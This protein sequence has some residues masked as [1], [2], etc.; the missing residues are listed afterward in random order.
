MWLERTGIKPPIPGISLRVAYHAPCS[1]Q[2]GQRV[3]GA[4]VALLRQAGFS[5]HEV[6]DG[7]LCCGSAGTYHLL[8]P[9]L[10]DQLRRRKIA[11]IESLQPQAIATGNLGCMLQI[12]SGTALPSLHL[13]QLL[14]WATG[15][16]KPPG[17]EGPAYR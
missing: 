15:G 1:L 6:P 10:A 4:P 5:V 8:Q 11:T 14:D 16:P 3:R 17:L 9:D 13:V 2:H 7:H 12:G